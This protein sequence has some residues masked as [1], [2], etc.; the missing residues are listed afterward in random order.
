MNTKKKTTVDSAG[1]KTR[2]IDGKN[3]GFVF[4]KPNTIQP[5]TYASPIRHEVFKKTKNPLTLVHGFTVPTIVPTRIPVVPVQARIP[6]APVQARIP[7]APVRARI[8]V[9]L[10]RARIPVAPVQARISVTPVLVTDHEVVKTKRLSKRA[11]IRKRDF[12]KKKLVIKEVDAQI[13]GVDYITRVMIPQTF[14]KKNDGI[15]SLF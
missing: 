8:S 13:N 12:M 1:G 15:Y 7:V 6:V 9:A 10:V 11:R 2:I 4:K 14:L 3:G 5:G